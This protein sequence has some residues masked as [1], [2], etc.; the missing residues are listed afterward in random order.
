MQTP[1][2]E[3][4]TPVLSLLRRLAVPA[5]AVAAGIFVI[6]F[7]ASHEAR[8]LAERPWVDGVLVPDSPLPGGDAEG[9]IPARVRRL[10][11]KMLDNAFAS[12]LRESP[13]G[14]ELFEKL[15][16]DKGAF[17]VYLEASPAT[18]GPVLSSGRLPR[19]GEREALAGDM[20]SPGPFDMD[21]TGFRVV[22]RLHRSVS[23]LGYAYVILES[24]ETKPL[25]SAESAA[26]KG[27]FDPRGI[28]RMTNGDALYEDEDMELFA[29]VARGDSLKTAGAI[30]GLMLVAIGG[31]VFQVRVLCWLGS[32][33]RVPLRAI[34]REMGERSL[35]LW[36]IHLL[37]YGAFFFS[38]LVALHYP[39][40]NYHL[41]TFVS[42]EFAT[43]S[44][45]QIG[46]AYASGNILSAALETL[47]HNFLKATLCFTIA[48]S[49]IIPGAGLAKNLLTFAVVG[50][51]MCPMWTGSAEVMAY[52]SI[53]MTLEMEAYVIASF[54]VIAYVLR[55]LRGIVDE[56]FHPQFTAAV[57]VMAG[58]AALAG[59]LLTFAALYEAATVITLG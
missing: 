13:G 58:G 50:F 40:V 1:E 26:T 3:V 23:G 7:V 14:E 29:G 38:M 33:G 32:H 56:E 8:Q 54:A 45:S 16:L 25:F 20:A 24:E 41:T 6:S 36:G 22:G 53:T 51:V 11:G 12:Q 2:T 46:E 19:P 35:L 17:I 5:L 28:E 37:L 52:H 59:I 21:G 39:L 47:K 34:L 10:P 44:L 48:P 4:P 30:L 15:G 49:I 31:A 18:L 42:G 55:L 43:G 57:R 27:W 9:L